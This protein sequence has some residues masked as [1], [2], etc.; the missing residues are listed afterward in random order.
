MPP[1]HGLMSGARSSPRIQTH[2]SWA[3]EAERANPTT[4]SPGWSH[5]SLI[6]KEEKP[7]KGSGSLSTIL[8]LVPHLIHCSL[9]FIDLS[10]GSMLGS[11]YYPKPHHEW[12]CEHWWLRI[13]TQ[14]YSDR[15]STLPAHWYHQ[16]GFYNICVP[17]LQWGLCICM[18]KELSWEARFNILKKRTKALL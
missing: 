13:T 17:G 11:G 18:R 16:R 7:L 4:T 14:G 3:A 5:K 10:M 8:Q 1:Q 9:H 2:E 12:S 6:L 15:F